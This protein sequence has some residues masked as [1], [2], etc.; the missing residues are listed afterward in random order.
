MNVS[1][2]FPALFPGDI[3]VSSGRGWL[4]WLLRMALKS[5]C[6]HTF[7]IMRWEP[8]IGEYSIIESIGKGVTIGLLSFYRN[9]RIAVLRPE[10]PAA[11]GHLVVASAIRLGRA[12]YDYRLIPRIALTLLLSRLRQLL[13][14]SWKEFLDWIRVPY[15]KNNRFICS[16][17]VVEAYARAGFHILPPGHIPLPSHIA[18]SDRLQTIFQGRV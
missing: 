11:A 18:D 16:E 2:S 14:E 7:L 3:V 10:I 6:S 13:P 1:S 5:P 8:S 12:R 15:W 9:Q 4:S 17:L